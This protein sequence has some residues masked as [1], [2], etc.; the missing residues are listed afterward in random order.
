MTGSP[1]FDPRVRCIPSGMPSMMNMFYGME[2]MQSKDKITMYGE[3]ND[4]YRRIFLDGRQPSRKVLNDPTYAG[5]STG[6]WEGNTLVVDTVA[7]RDDSLIEDFV[8][9]SP[10]SDKMT[11]HERIRLIEPGV[12][13]DRMTVTD[14][15]AF[16][17][18]FEMV[19]TYRKASLPSDELREFACAEGL[20]KVK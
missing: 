13:E 2:L 1:E 16:L 6:H 7:L 10:H 5:Y 20:A 15:E 19:R 18:P 4:M 9:F 12:L 17:E 14:A 11:V 8:A 3:M